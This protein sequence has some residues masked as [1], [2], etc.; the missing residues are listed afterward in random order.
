MVTREFKMKTL[1]LIC[2]LLASSLLFAK[3]APIDKWEEKRNLCDNVSEAA[4]SIMKA[5]Q[6]G[7]SMKDMYSY[8]QVL[9]SETRPIFESFIKAAYNVQIADTEY[10]SAMLTLEFSNGAFEGCMELS[11]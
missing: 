3:S 9:D 7:V 4:E 11:D 5:R 1:I 6:R 10:E 8:L 2:G